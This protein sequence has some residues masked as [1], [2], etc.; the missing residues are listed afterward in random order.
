MTCPAG[1]SA[2]EFTNAVRIGVQNACLGGNVQC[3]HSPIL[4]SGTEDGTANLA[5]FTLLACCSILNT[6]PGGVDALSYNC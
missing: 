2:D 6:L 5:L 1:I 4:V 3:S